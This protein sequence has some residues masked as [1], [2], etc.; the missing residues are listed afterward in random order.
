[1]TDINVVPIIQSLTHIPYHTVL[2]MRDYS[3]GPNLEG[4]LHDLTQ[5]TFARSTST[6]AQQRQ[7][8]ARH[9]RHTAHRQDFFVLVFMSVY[10]V[11]PC[12][13]KCHFFG[14]AP[15]GWK[16]GLIVA[17]SKGNECIALGALLWPMPLSLVGRSSLI[18]NFDTA[19]QFSSSSHQSNSGQDSGQFYCTMHETRAWTIYCTMHKTKEKQRKV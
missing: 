14:H 8:H 19:C 2:N 17:A 11:C 6:V 7:A 3:R 18:V 10:W 5:G 9:S 12:H 13:G 16:A 4:A 1:M 15:S